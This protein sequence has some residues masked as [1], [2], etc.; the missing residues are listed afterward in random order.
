MKKYFYQNPGGKQFGP[1][2][3]ET[4]RTLS[5]D[6]TIAA[7]AMVRAEGVPQWLPAATI[8]TT[9]AALSTSAPL[10]GESATDANAQV[11]QPTWVHSE[12]EQESNEILVGELL[13]AG[14]LRLPP[15]LL[16]GVVA[17]T[18]CLTLDIFFHSPVIVVALFVLLLS[19]VC[20]GFS[21]GIHLP[22][23]MAIYTIPLL[24]VVCVIVHFSDPKLLGSSPPL[25]DPGKTPI[26]RLVYALGYGVIA[27]LGAG[28]LGYIVGYFIRS[29]RPDAE[30]PPLS[31]PFE[32]PTAGGKEIAIRIN[33]STV[34][35][36]N[37]GLR[38]GDSGTDCEV[39]ANGSAST[40]FATSHDEITLAVWVIYQ[41]NATSLYTN[42]PFVA[43]VGAENV[44]HVT[45]PH[46]D[47]RILDPL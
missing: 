18:F 36:I 43:R 26:L 42:I 6:G 44:I 24:I 14:V 30:L 12:P 46:A 19:F 40:S 13:P 15:V 4:L 35:P 37:V 10:G 22:W 41:T 3:L 47:N 23:K 11:T 7:N 1:L 33:N 2:P 16:L 17:F 32:A 9:P 45:M 8:L 28:I 39:A 21:R 27:G 29:G 25:L 38:S 31:R 20:L 5:A 34:S